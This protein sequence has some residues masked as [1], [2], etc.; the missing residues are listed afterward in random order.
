[1]ADDDQ[2]VVGEQPPLGA[3]A[4]GDQG[5][6][7]QGDQLQGAQHQGDQHQGD[8]YQGDQHQGPPGDLQGGHQLDPPVLQG[9]GDQ[10]ADQVD[11]V[12]DQPL[13]GNPGGVAPGEYT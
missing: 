2:G 5:D 7:H 10:A 1:M 12:L 4:P 6:Q 11:P 13:Y 8:Q 9:E 3:G